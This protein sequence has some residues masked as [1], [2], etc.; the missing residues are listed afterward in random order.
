[1]N[2]YISFQK[3]YQVRKWSVLKF[4]LLLLE[5]LANEKKLSKCTVLWSRNSTTFW[6]FLFVWR[7]DT[8]PP[9]LKDTIFLGW[10][11]LLSDVTILSPFN[12]SLSHYLYLSLL[13]WLSSKPTPSTSRLSPLIT[14]DLPWRECRIISKLFWIIH[15]TLHHLSYLCYLVHTLICLSWYFSLF[16]LL[17]TIFSSLLC[18]FFKITYSHGIF[19]CWIKCAIV[20]LLSS[21]FLLDLTA[22]I[23][24][25]LRSA[26]YPLLCSVVPCE[27][28]GWGW[29]ASPT[30]PSS[31]SMR[32]G[33]TALQE[34]LPSSKTWVSIG[35]PLGRKMLMG[36]FHFRTLST[37]EPQS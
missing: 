21:S 1:M 32:I 24:L 15:I 18:L 9:I 6:V 36:P 31:R 13:L 23:Y 29:S 37:D 10:F 33:T 12:L 20:T 25:F 7:C 3:E 28:Q 27:G 8:S 35:S 22:V 34:S 5:V 4:A 30:T 11:H 16:F 19:F 14:E 2:I 26:F 17:F